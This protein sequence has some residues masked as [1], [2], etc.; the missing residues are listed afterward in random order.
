MKALKVYLVNVSLGLA[1]TEKRFANIWQ[2]LRSR[3]NVRP[4]LVIPETLQLAL[5]GAGLI[6]RSGEADIWAIKERSVLRSA[7][8]YCPGLVKRIPRSAGIR[9]RLIALE[10]RKAL[11]VIPTDQRAIIHFG[12][13]CNL[14]PPP[15]MPIVY[16]CMDSTF[17][18]FDA[19]HFR[20]AAQR[21]CIVNCQSERIKI[22]LDNSK[23][24]SG[25]RWRTVVSPCYFA[26]YVDQPDDV[27]SKRELETV[28]FMGRFS[29]EKSPLLFVEAMFLL[30]ERGFKVK[31]VMLGEG[32]MQS[33]IEDRRNAYGLRNSLFV[34]FTKSPEIYL[35]QANIFVSL[36]T[37]DNF[38][39]QA[40]LEAMAAGCSI[41]ATD[42]GETY[43]LVDEE[44]G[45]RV[46]HSPRALADAIQLFL[47]SP[48]RMRICGDSAAKRVRAE[49]TA[50]AYAKHLELIY[51]DAFLVYSDSK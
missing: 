34:G 29:E 9:T 26:H 22:A 49:Y 27:I 28:L 12:V 38:G 15:D 42:V 31:G 20:R 2:A 24:S 10:F 25:A 30:H 19:K 16:E 40:L 11:S 37:G 47:S 36:Q 3:G 51:E 23:A 50:D 6:P 21:A 48:D 33:L 43:R 39:S 46:P 45:I 18:S 44:V 1:G 17:E 14:L 8:N 4:I 13:P 41:V 35:Q 7:G 5:A 32:P